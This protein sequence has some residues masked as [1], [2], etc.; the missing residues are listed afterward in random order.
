MAMV[1]AALVAGIRLVLQGPLDV[2]PVRVGDVALG[3][4]VDVLSVVLLGFVGCVGALV[5]A[6]SARNLVGQARTGRFGWL[7][8]IALTSLTVLVAGASLPVIAAGWTVSGMALAALVAQPA[9]ESSRRAAGYVRRT[10]L[11]G[12]AAVWVGVALALVLLPT[13]NR[14]ELARVELPGAGSTIVA[15]LLI[16]GCVV[17]SALVPAQSWLP[18]TAEAPSPVSAFLH[19]GIVNGAGVLV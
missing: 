15:A 8:L 11:V 19:A 12:D 2:V 18:E 9:T 13:V 7:L 10:L 16:V 14:S 6:Y 5:A 4:R 1:L 17:R 3:L